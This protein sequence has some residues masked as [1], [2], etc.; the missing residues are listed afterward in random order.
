MRLAYL[1]ASAREREQLAQTELPGVSVAAYEGT[2]TETLAP[3][4]A[5]ELL[6]V[7]VGS[8]IGPAELAQLP[9]LRFIATRSTGFDHID[10]AACQKRGIVVS[11][12]PVYGENTVAEH[13]FALILALSRRIFQAYERTER[14]DFDREGLE[15]FDVNGKTLGVVGCGN[16]GRHS[17]RIGRGFGMTV[18]AYDVKPDQTLAKQTG[19]TFVP[20]LAELLARSDVVTLHVPYLPAKTHHLLSREQFAQMKRGAVL[21]NTSRG[22]IIDTAALLWALDEGILSGAG[23]DVLEG[24]DD[25]FDHVALLSQQAPAQEQL[26]AVLR[27]H[28][29]LARN[30][31]IITPHNAFN[32]REA[33]ARIFQ[34]T[35]ENIKAYV[36][37]APTRTV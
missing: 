30:D 15:G 14:L 27:N 7:F 35:V 25:T 31:V 1:E 12:V 19:C 10:V 11:N 16:I 33:R 28:A 9:R 8:R 3:A 4:Q 5:A 17:V 34:T 36:S 37:G 23:L 24:E 29:L 2:L 26:A 20:T 21:V 13:T 22:A 18:L 6:S 32:S